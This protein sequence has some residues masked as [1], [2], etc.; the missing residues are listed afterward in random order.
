MTDGEVI[1]KSERISTRCAR[2]FFQAAER[3]RADLAVLMLKVVI[4]PLARSGHGRKTFDWRTREC[5]EQGQKLI[6]CFRPH[7]SKHRMHRRHLLPPN[8]TKSSRGP[9]DRQA[10]KEHLEWA[11]TRVAQADSRVVAQ[12]KLVA[13]LERERGH[14]AA[15]RMLLAELELSLKMRIADRDRLRRELAQQGLILR[16]QIGPSPGPGA[17]RRPGRR[18]LRH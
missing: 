18:A 2:Y 14:T 11:E 8:S 17:P 15:A 5:R 6:R 3:Q 1:A 10:L 16:L 13:K 12:R 7:G 4:Q 9:M